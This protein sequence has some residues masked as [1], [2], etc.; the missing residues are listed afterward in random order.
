[1]L[2]I[3]PS[4]STGDGNGCTLYARG[5]DVEE[6]EKAVS[7]NRETCRWT[8]QGE[9]SEVRRTDERGAILSALE[10][11]VEPMTPKEIQIATKWRATT[12][13]NCCSR[14]QRL[15]RC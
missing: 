2:P 5:R 3:P 13:I 15:A 6:Y 9:A 11:A 1:M 14:W 4:F 7:F 12:W 10:D 8:L